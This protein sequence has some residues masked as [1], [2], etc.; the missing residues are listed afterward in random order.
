MQEGAKCKSQTASRTGAGMI[1]IHLLSL[2]GRGSQSRIVGKPCIHLTDHGIVSP[3][4]GTKHR[5]ASLGAAQH[6]FHVAGN[7]K[8]AVSQFFHGIPRADAGQLLQPL[9]TKSDGFPCPVQ[10]FK[11]Q[12]LQHSHTAVIGDA[13]ADTDDKFPASLFDGIPDRLPH[14]VSRSI[15]G[16]P[17]LRHDHGDARRIRHLHDCRDAVLQNAIPPCHALS[18]RSR[19][20]QIPDGAAHAAD[21][22][23][24]RSLAAVRQRT[25]LCDRVR[26]DSFDPGR[27]SLSR[28]LR[29][30]AALKRIYGYDCFHSQPSNFY[31]FRISFRPITD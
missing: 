13:A 6:I 10:E 2:A 3:F 9:C 25:N 18:Q 28:L 14:S 7:M 12:R 26:K 31:C 19:N 11:A 22:R 17:F 1:G 27:R 30:Q 15:Q 5:A 16:I 29:G 23:F 24:H 4:L 21:Q 20:G 8:L